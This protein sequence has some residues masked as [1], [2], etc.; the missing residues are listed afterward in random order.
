MFHSTKFQYDSN[1]KL[2]VWFPNPCLFQSTKFQF[3]S[4]FKI[5]FWIKIKFILS[6]S[7]IRSDTMIKILQSPNL[8]LTGTPP[9]H[10][11]WSQVHA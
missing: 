5:P 10:L 3:D 6:Q 1:Y 2:L 9:V 11:Y 7:Y 8:V 4:K